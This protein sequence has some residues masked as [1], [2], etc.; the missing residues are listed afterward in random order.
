MA[1]SSWS[2]SMAG[3][4]GRRTWRA[5]AAV[6]RNTMMAMAKAP[7]SRS[8][9]RSNDTPIGDGRPEGTSPMSAT[10]CS[11]SEA[12]ATSPMPSTTATSGPGTRGA[13]RLSTR[14]RAI[15]AAE[16]TRVTTLRSPSWSSTAST[17]S[18]K[19]VAVGSPGMPSSFGSWPAATVRPTPNL[20]PVRVASE[21]LS[22][23]R[24]DAQDRARRRTAP[25]SRV[26]VARSR[27]G[28]A[29][30]AATPAA[31]RVDPVRTATVEV[32]LTDSVREPPSRA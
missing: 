25:T 8:S 28:S 23:T 3:S 30:S 14:T 11:S 29:P 32:V 15:V 24:A 31:S 5:T 13:T 12:K 10:P 2:L 27:A 6:S 20:M 16:N 22:M 21:M 7:P 9:I 18:K 26:S 4:S 17:S 1:S 19:P